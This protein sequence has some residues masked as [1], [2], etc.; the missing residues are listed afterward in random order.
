M[1]RVKYLLSFALALGISSHSALMASETEINVTITPFYQ[2]TGGGTFYPEV[3]FSLPFATTEVRYSLT[4]TQVTHLVDRIREIY[5]QALAA[6]PSIGDPEYDW[7]NNIK[8]S[9][10]SDPMAGELDIVTNILTEAQFNDPLEISHQDG[11]GYT[12]GSLTYGS[13]DPSYPLFN[14]S[15]SEFAATENNLAYTV[16]NRGIS[17]LAS[18]KV[19]MDFVFSC[20]TPANQRIENLQLI[21]DAGGST[22]IRLVRGPDAT[23]TAGECKILVEI[24]SFE[25][26]GILSFTLVDNFLNRLLYS[27]RFSLGVI[28]GN[29]V[30]VIVGNTAS[31]SSGAES[32]G[33]KC[34]GII[35]GSSSNSLSIV[36]M[37]LL[38]LLGLFGLRSSL[39]KPA[40]AK[41]ASKRR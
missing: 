25:V 11:I 20:P 18:R 15:L 7:I 21:P 33:G 38:A 26:T 9:P 10:I 30:G 16:A 40:I 14:V 2:A 27:S 13:G 22:P 5:A 3:Y 32:G 23:G 29:T 36:L 6:N 1:K 37:T 8:N 24:D 17:S 34:G 35:D 19:T 41:A 12:V 28:V 31:N 39:W 4:A